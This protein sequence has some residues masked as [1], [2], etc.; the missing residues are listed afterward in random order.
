MAWRLASNATSCSTPPAGAKAS[1]TENEYFIG[2]IVACKDPHG[3]YQ[4]IDGQQRLTTLYLFLCLLRDYM[5]R[6]GLTVQ[7]SLRGMIGS[8]QT[9]D[10][11]NEKF[12]YR[13]SLQYEDSRGILE[14]IAAGQTA[15]ESIAADTHSIRNLLDAYA[16]LD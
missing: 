6:H 5:K 3:T 14:K 10:Y 1:S 16:T 7:D 13:L 12:Q 4:L 8:P 2:S 9:D 11:G 15:I